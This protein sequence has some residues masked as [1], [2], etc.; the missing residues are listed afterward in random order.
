MIIINTKFYSLYK[1][2]QERIINSAFKEFAK[3]GYEMASTNEI[4]K[5]AEISKGS[6]FSYFTSK[7]GLYLFLLDYVLVIIDKIYEELNY[8]E[9]DFFNRTRDLG[10]VKFRIMKKYPKVFDFLNTVTKEDAKELKEEIER[11]RTRAIEN[12]LEKGYK[13]IDWTKFRQDMDLSKMMKIINWTFLSFSEEQRSKLNSYENMGTE[14]LN[15][16]DE[17]FDILKRSFYK[18]DV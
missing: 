13:N 10:L 4:I 14:V 16:W 1:E 9:T 2:K 17:Y 8:D 11:I 5:D 3:N 12:G 15:E 6:L 7:R 18:Q